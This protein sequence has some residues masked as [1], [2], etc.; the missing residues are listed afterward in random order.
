[1]LTSYAVEVPTGEGS[2]T[3]GSERITFNRATFKYEISCRENISDAELQE[4]LDYSTITKAS[5]G[6]K[7]TAA[8]LKA[9]T[10]DTDAKAIKISNV[11]AFFNS[12]SNLARFKLK[13]AAANPILEAVDG[14]E[15]SEEDN[16]KFIEYAKLSSLDNLTSEDMTYLK[17]LAK[18][19]LDSAETCKNY[20]NKDEMT[21]LYNSANTAYG[22]IDSQETNT[23]KENKIITTM[24]NSFQVLIKSM[25]LEIEN[26]PYMQKY[27][28]GNSQLFNEAKNC[29]NVGNPSDDTFG[30]AY[31]TLTGVYDA[32]AED[33]GNITAAALIKCVI[34][35]E[36]GEK[37]SNLLSVVKNG[38]SKRELISDENLKKVIDALVSTD[39]NTMRYWSGYFNTDS[40]IA[41]MMF[42]IQNFFAIHVKMK[43]ELVKVP[44][45]FLNNL[46]DM[47]FDSNLTTTDITSETSQNLD[48]FTIYNNSTKKA[49]LYY[50]NNVIT[51]EIPLDL[52]ENTSTGTAIKYFTIEPDSTFQCRIL[53]APVAK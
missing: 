5:D 47:T 20:M 17:G 10:D 31:D 23:D 41:P 40:N 46:T 39:F 19:T 44:E 34:D 9:A 36:Y 53:T 35:N 38:G 13:H 8:D 15:L 28:N 25:F 4:V 1:M 16:A 6:Q 32:T 52:P 2:A 51:F 14:I 7:P 27:S 12:T 43:N 24:K 45:M 11:G 30:Y 21:S 29:L 49:K 22:E 37:S 50:K 26:L 33:A 3:F 42:A 48:K 18:K